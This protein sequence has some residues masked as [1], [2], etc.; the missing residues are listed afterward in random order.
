[1]GEADVVVMDN[2]EAANHGDATGR[3]VE[4]APRESEY[5]AVWSPE[6]HRVAGQR[7]RERGDSNAHVLADTLDLN[8]AAPIYA[9]GRWS[10]SASSPRPN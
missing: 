8:R 4:V 1:M 6:Y 9:C 5:F 2:G 7:G 10:C 3:D